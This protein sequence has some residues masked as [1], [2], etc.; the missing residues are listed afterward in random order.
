MS[1]AHLVVYRSLSAKQRTELAAAVNKDGHL[2][3]YSSGRWSHREGNRR[4]AR[5]VHVT[6]LNRLRERGLIEWD[7][8]GYMP[9]EQGR[10]VIAAGEA[11]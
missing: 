1:H 8:Y 5:W 10:R 3:P 9:T 11:A 7:N 2:Y 6:T 4:G